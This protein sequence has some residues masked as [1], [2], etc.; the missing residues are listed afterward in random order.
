MCQTEAFPLQAGFP[1]VLTQE[2]MWHTRPVTSSTL[3][4]VPIA[5]REMYA[6]HQECVVTTQNLA[7]ISQH[8][9]D[10]VNPGLAWVPAPLCSALFSCPSAL[11]LEVL[12]SQVPSSCLLPCSGTCARTLSH[13]LVSRLALEAP[14]TSYLSA[15][16]AQ[17]CRLCE[18]QVTLP[19][20]EGDVLKK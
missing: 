12:Q 11:G 14:L 6:F 10:R 8:T 18:M 2:T 15:P 16:L 1:Q 9:V 20:F 3:V 17:R 7:E 4:F 13:S 5:S 19:S